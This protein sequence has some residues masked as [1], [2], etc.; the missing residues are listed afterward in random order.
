MLLFIF[1]LT[2]AH[3]DFLAAETRHSKCDDYETFTSA[4]HPDHKITAVKIV[5]F[6]R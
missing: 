4:P 3:C 6:D 1:Y 5:S 2:W